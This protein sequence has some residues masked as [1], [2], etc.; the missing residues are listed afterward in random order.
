[1]YLQYHVFDYIHALGSLFAVSMKL[2]NVKKKKQKLGMLK[3]CVRENG[4]I[5]FSTLIS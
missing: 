1:M 2:Y 4:N 5:E 3:K